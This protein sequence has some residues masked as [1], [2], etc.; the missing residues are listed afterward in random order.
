[1][2][3]Q[4]NPPW[5]KSP[6]E[7]L[8]RRLPPKAT[9]PSYLEAMHR[10]FRAADTDTNGEI[11]EADAVLYQQLARATLRAAFISDLLRADLDGDG[12][13]TEEELRTTLRQQRYASNP[14]VPA[15]ST[16]EAQTEIQ[17]RQFM[18]ADANHD[19]RIT[20][21]E[22]RNY[23]DSRPGLMELGNFAEG[24]VRQ[25]LVFA[26]EGKSVLTLADF[27]TA[28]EKFFRELDTDGDGVIS[29][30]EL[31]AFDARR[32][33]SRAPP[34]S[35]PQQST[36]AATASQQAP[37]N[38]FMPRHTMGIPCPMPK[39]SD[40]A[41]LVLIG[42]NE[43]TALSSVTIGSQDVA[44][45]VGNITVEAGTEPIYLV[46]TS[47]QPTIWRLYGA[48]ERIEQLVLTSTLGPVIKGLPPGKPLVGAIGIAADRVTFLPK[49]ACLEQFTTVQSAAASTAAVAVKVD[50]GRDVAVV[51]GIYGLSDVWV[52]S[53]AIHGSSHGKF[54]VVSKGPV[55]IKGDDDPNVIVTTDRAA[56]DIDLNSFYPG[57]VVEIDPKRVV[58][59]MPVER[60]EVLPGRAGLAQLV[61]AGKLEVKDGVFLI[62]EKIHF[63]AD[64]NG[65]YSATFRLLRGV[66]MP[67]GNPGNSEVISEETGQPIKFD[68]A[69]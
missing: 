52:P 31:K 23:V 11:S 4:T 36:R 37:D 42:S 59:S 35:P 13:V 24:G 15:G 30:D 50:T 12:I 56:V 27:D 67:D 57:G 9:L 16:P 5:I 60:Y 34:P 33:A 49:I 48:V 69:R 26:P 32:A 58:A 1:M 14:Q 2:S 64:L 8:L 28:V 20:F 40:A 62:K 61:K 55:T 51:A 7:F 17:I 38:S 39:P 66:P 65:V 41:K 68:V 43:T 6:T 53:G 46:V 44:V 3:R 18:A 22:A 47:Y 29:T 21:D 19:G 63:P 25:L 54:L 45:G 10:D